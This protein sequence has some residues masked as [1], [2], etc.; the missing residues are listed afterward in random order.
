M[1]QGKT[2]TFIALRRKEKN[3]TQVQLAEKLNITNR[4][5]S[6]WE[7]GKAMPDAS[8][9]LELCDILDIT[10]TELLRGERLQTENV[11]K[12]SEITIIDLLNCNKQM[13]TG[14]CVSEMMSG[15]GVGIL[16]SLLDRPDTVTKTVL[17]IVGVGMFL[18]GWHYRNKLEK[19]KFLLLGS[20]DYRK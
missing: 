12:Q 7:T 1:D 5:V 2:G 17:L 16:L 15:G 9:M 3:L 4:A 10:V 19:H 18:W 13:Q 20:V 8:I 6:K 14:K 11:Q